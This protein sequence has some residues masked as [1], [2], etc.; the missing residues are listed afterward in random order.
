METKE[1]TVYVVTSGDYS[2]YHIDAV[3]TDKALAE[4]FA[5]T[6]IDSRIEEYAVNEKKEKTELWWCVELGEHLEKPLISRS[7]IAHDLVERTSEKYKRYSFIVKSSSITRAK[8]IALERYH[9]FLAVKDTHFPFI[10]TPYILDGMDFFLNLSR[11]YLSYGYFD[12]K[13]YYIHGVNLRELFVDLMHV[14][15]EDYRN[16]PRQPDAILAELKKHGLDLHSNCE[17]ER[18]S[19]VLDV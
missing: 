12:Y 8:A 17:L 13:A 7:P 1:Q 5:D 2:D 19:I 3:F 9:A 6:I 11:C 18:C 4:N 16:V 10:D 14:K 15:R